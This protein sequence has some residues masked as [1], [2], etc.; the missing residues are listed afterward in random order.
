[1]R[2]IDRRNQARGGQRNDRN[3]NQITH[4]VI[5]H[6]ASARTATT[7][8]FEQ[9]V[10]RNQ[11]WDRGG[12]HEV[13]L[14]SGDVERN[15]DD[16][17]I[18]WGAANQNTHTWH[19]ALVGQHGK[20]INNITSQ[21]LRSVEGRIAEA[22]RRIGITKVDR[23]VVHNALPGQAT[24]CTS[25][26]ITNIRTAVGNL[27]ATPA[28]IPTPPANNNN[29]ASNTTTHTVRNGETL[30]GIALQ[31]RTTVAELQRLNNI[32]NPNLIRIGQVLRLPN[33]SNNTA[34]ATNNT[35]RIGS[36]VHVNQNAQRWV[37]GQN[38]PASVRAQIY[39][40]QQ[41]GRNG[42]NNHI[43]IGRN[44]VATGWINRSDVTAV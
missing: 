26:N 20:G 4:I 23:I 31:H 5:H 40:V 32:S 19:I 1:M 14:A 15:Y 17:R 44:R 10:W 9:G 28:P 27:L 6:T 24:A 41:I 35:I 30:S 36:R 16:R 11:G 13:V 42:N 21:Q 43:L 33:A 25:V 29:T 38:I 22:M 7:Q 34:P 2:I 3:L 12:Y 39:D 8:T 18:V 37:T